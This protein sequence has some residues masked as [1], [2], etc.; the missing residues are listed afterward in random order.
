M[1]FVLNAPN[2]ALQPGCSHPYCAVPGPAPHAAAA[3]PARWRC[4]AGL[5]LSLAFALAA[6]APPASGQTV[7]RRLTRWKIQSAAHFSA[8]GAAVSRAGFSTAGW[9]PARV[10]G[11]VVSNLIRD[12]IYPNPYFGM[13]LRAFPGET[14]PIGGNFSNLPMPPDSPFRHP[15]WYRTQFR[16]AAV[17][18]GRQYWLHFHGINF[19]AS[20][21]LN[22]H[23]LA[24]SR[25]V[26]GTWRIFAFNITPYLR[27]GV[28]VLAAKA[29]AE[30]PNDLALTFVDW[31]PLPPDKD[32]GLF[33][34]VFITRTGAVSLWH[35]QVRTQLDLPFAG[36]APFARGAKRA[37]EGRE[38]PQGVPPPASDSARPPATRRLGWGGLGSPAQPA[39]KRD[40]RRTRGPQRAAAR[41]GVGSRAGARA[42]QLL[43]AAHLTIS[44]HLRNSASYTVRGMLVARVGAITLR[45]EV[46]LGPGM[47]R[48]VVFR[49][50]RFPALN[51]VHPR[52]WWPYE[53]GPQNLYHLHLAFIAAGRVTDRKTVVFGIRQ[54][55]SRLDARNHRLFFVNG[56]RILIRG[57]GWAANM[58]MDLSA[59]NELEQLQYVR[60][61]HLNAIRLEGKPMDQTFY[62]LCDRLGILV[63][64]GWCC[65]SRWQHWK[66]WKPADYVI[67]AASERDQL[68]RLRNHP[69]V[70][71]WLYGSDIAP[72]PA[73][74]RIYLRVIRQ[75]H[76]PNAVVAGASK[77]KTLVGWTGVKMS[78]PYQYVAPNYWENPHAPGGAF[79]FNTETS[80]GPAIPVLASL[81]EMLPRADLWPMDQAWNYHAGGGEFKN[82][83]YFTHAQAARYG[84]STTLRD[85]E[86]KAQ[87]M[88]Y[89]GERAM[90]E[91]YGRNKWVSTGIIQWMLSN[92]WPSMIWHLYDY[93]LRPGGGF[94]GAQ[95]ACQPVHIQYSYDDGSIW[96]VN[97]LLRDFTG[98]ARV[99]VYSFHLRRLLQ[100]TLDVSAPGNRSVRIFTL[101]KFAHLSPVYF[102]R[103]RLTAAQSRGGRRVVS[104]NFYWLAR[105]PDTYNWAKST[106]YYSPIVHYANLTE[107]QSL[108][109]V[110]LRLSAAGRRHG[111][112]ETDVVRLRNPSHHLAFQVHLVVL[113]GRHG[114]DIEPAIWQA[115]YLELMPG[116]SRIVHV[117][118]RAA[119]L[120]GAR[121]VIRA[122]GWNI[123]RQFAPVAG[124]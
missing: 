84:P 117:R 113:R 81:R 97:S 89:A 47:D 63:I 108:P 91:A 86:H 14:Y 51:F 31:N 94:F 60:A 106:W 29:Y 61:M 74:E 16:L 70:L 59:R 92:G 75:T 40:A 71:V 45:R 121:P 44:A 21:W 33:R 52:L 119:L 67:A 55:S 78:G 58:L 120:H 35:P 65:C 90:F 54:V 10:P 111:G 88:A 114:G 46:F 64:Q 115:N 118:Y 116:A 34:R 104:R 100:K 5:G 3:R 112:W 56:H 124:K 30:T 105:H 43:A 53:W 2:R 83:N 36:A 13:N 23:K 4:L 122:G 98:R 8:G 20:I 11:T 9:F 28:N 1:P 24:G 68:Q 18:P 109:P 87:A 103:L 50:A 101:P 15:W 27:R 77:Q 19:R 41:V 85:Y 123:P 17:Q 73:V 22:G 32:M 99:Q 42:K 49:P 107:L 79:G 72:P 6:F 96:V 76:W 57:A 102:V 69:S 66:D 25:H 39:R 37:R 38:I 93:Y 12:K 82:L 110:R 26:A 95:T 7:F 48:R 80:P 62:R